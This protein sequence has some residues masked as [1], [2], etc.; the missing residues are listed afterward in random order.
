MEILERR[1]RKE[2][3]FFFTPP[4]NGRNVSSQKDARFFSRL[5]LPVKY[6]K[7]RGGREDWSHQYL[8]TEKEQK[9]MRIPEE[10]EKKKKK[11]T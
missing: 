7:G 11:K 8:P 10:E 5:F 2:S 6:W 1:R 3:L 4:Y 9:L